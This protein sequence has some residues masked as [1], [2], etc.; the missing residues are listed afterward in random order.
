MSGLETEQKLIDFFLNPKNYPERPLAVSH[1]ETH[2]S[3]VFIGDHFVYKVKKPVNFGF[4]DFSTLKKRRLFCGKEVLLNSRLAK[5]IYLGVQPIYKSDLGYRFDPQGGS[6]PVEYSVKMRRIPLDCLLF[7]LI[8]EGRPLYGAMEDVGGTLALFHGNAASYRGRKF[9]GIE[10][11]R[12]AIEENFEQIKPFTALTIDEKI[13]GVLTTYTSAF[14]TG[15]KDTFAAR[16]RNGYVRD[17]HGDL[18][19]QHICLNHP[20]IIFDCVEFNEGFRI[21][22]M[23]EDIAFLFMDL[24]YRGR[25]D[26]SS[27]LYQVYV[28][29]LPKVLDEGLLRFYKV[30]RA[31]VRG[32]VESFTARNIED[33]SEREKAIARAR[34]YFGLADYY[35]NYFQKPFNPVVFMGLSGS[36]KSTIATNFS[37]NA[38]ILRSDEIRKEIAGLKKG[39]HAYNPFGAGIYTPELTRKIYRLMLDKA[40]EYVKQGKKVVVDAT[41][42]KANQRKG[43]HET[44][45]TNGL[46]PFFINCFANEA[47]LKER[48]RKRMEAGTDVSDAD[49]SILEHQLE[50]FEQ[51]DE[52]P[53]YRTLRINTE[54]AIHNIVHALREF[55]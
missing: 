37:P 28:T 54:D 49:L 16:K 46:N 21:I 34:D 52:L 48:I 24:E 11:I 12:S 15:H 25:F 1:L 32:K 10:S 36:G 45:I 4:L 38:V 43:F 30:Y 35:I 13:F 41:Y 14:L 5:E 20:P 18:H 3:H 9:G 47:V 42:L 19:C 53:Y 23:L 26:L 27:R 40:L 31:V 29:R 33:S 8:D 2:I 50:H 22:D 55:L 6:R 44:C 51:P 7:K 39:K 17:G